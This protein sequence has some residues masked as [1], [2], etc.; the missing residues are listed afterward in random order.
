[1]ACLLASEHYNTSIGSGGV[2]GGNKAEL[3]R[4]VLK[5]GL[6]AR[7]SRRSA[8]YNRSPSSESD[9]CEMLLALSRV[10]RRSLR[11]RILSARYFNRSSSS[12]A[13]IP[14]R[15]RAKMD[16]QRLEHVLD[17]LEIKSLLIRERY[18][19]DT[20]QWDKLRSCY[21]PDASKTFIDI[22][23]FTGDIDG[24]VTGSRAMSQGGVGAIHTIN[25]V[26]VTIHGNKALSESTGNIQIRTQHEG[27]EYDLVS[28]TRF[29]SR[30]ARTPHGW[31]LLTL[32]VIYD[33][34][35][36]TSVVPTQG[37][38]IK[39]NDL[40]RRK[41]YRCVSWVLS[42][43]GFQ[44][45]QSLPGTDWPESITNLMNSANHWLTG[46]DGVIK[47]DGLVL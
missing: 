24:F 45:K 33:R 12:T 7:L 17:D 21:H 25:P 40:G 47:A 32:D 30:L 42:E 28:W 19:R 37:S 35:T 8:V 1:M 13:L 31:K 41:S 4:E 14:P 20:C 18:Y 10:P 3:D 39:L 9:V 11:S 36:L 38:V 16:S 34:D 15:I 26:E 29:I 2:L 5:P 43:R 46:G 22:S 6:R 27:Q 23:W 44:I